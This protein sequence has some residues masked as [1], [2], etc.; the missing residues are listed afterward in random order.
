MTDID[1]ARELSDASLI[2]EH[3]GDAK[4]QEYM[5]EVRFFV[6]ASSHEDAT[7]MVDKILNSSSYYDCFKEVETWQIENTEEV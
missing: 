3:W 1:R 6:N 2:D 7:V 4:E 5:V